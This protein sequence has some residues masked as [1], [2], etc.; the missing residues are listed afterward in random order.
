MPAYDYRCIAC[1]HV[2]EVEQTYEEHDKDFDH[3]QGRAVRCPGCGSKKLEHLI[4]PSV[5]VITSKKS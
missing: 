4:A 1:G 2:F 3:E 5:H